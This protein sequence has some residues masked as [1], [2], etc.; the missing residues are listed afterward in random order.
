VVDFPLPREANSSTT[1]DRTNAGIISA[2]AKMDSFQIV[3]QKLGYSG[4]GL[5][6]VPSCLANLY[7]I[8]SAKIATTLGGASFPTPVAMEN[9]NFKRSPSYMYSFICRDS[10][11]TFKVSKNLNQNS[12][13]R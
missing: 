12:T 8:G 1:V 10:E 5:G 11:F 9:T 3:C 7:Q 6:K 2:K 13:H 4:F